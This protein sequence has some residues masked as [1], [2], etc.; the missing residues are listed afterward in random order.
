[1]AVNDRKPL[2]VVAEGME[3]IIQRD[4]DK[5]K[6]FL[7]AAKLDLQA[8]RQARSHEVQKKKHYRKQIGKGKFNDEA[9]EEARVQMAINIRHLSDKA[10]LAERRIAHETEIV[11]TLTQQLEDQM[12]GLS[13]LRKHRL[14]HEDA[15]PS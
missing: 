5:H 11:E 10:D 14:E 8:F 12:A 6:S 15:S 2:E 9:L 4:L 3:Q 13:R 1:M 7:E